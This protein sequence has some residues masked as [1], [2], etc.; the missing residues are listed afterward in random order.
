MMDESVFA[1]IREGEARAAARRQR[2]AIE[3]TIQAITSALVLADLAAKVSSLQRYTVPRHSGEIVPI[4]GESVLESQ[5]RIIDAVERGLKG[6]SGTPEPP[7][8]KLVVS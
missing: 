2:E 8:V 7:R 6:T 3:I 1:P 4:L 5:R